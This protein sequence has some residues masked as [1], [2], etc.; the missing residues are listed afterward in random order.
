MSFGWGVTGRDEF[1]ARTV[2]KNASSL[3]NNSCRSADQT[4][5]ESVV[6]FLVM[7]TDSIEYGA[8]GVF[9]VDTRNDAA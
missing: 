5:V 6:V 8:V 4:K 9:G 1:L 3:G 2:A 7:A